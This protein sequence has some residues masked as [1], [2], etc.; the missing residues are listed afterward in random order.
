MGRNVDLRT[1]LYLPFFRTGALFSAGLHLSPALD[2]RAILGQANI[3]S[4]I[5]VDSAGLGQIISLEESADG[6]TAWTTVPDSD[7]ENLSFPGAAPFPGAPIANVAFVTRVAMN[8]RKGFLRM[9][10][11]QPGAGISAA[12]F[13]YMGWP[14]QA[15]APV[16]E[17][18]FL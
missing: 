2:V 8:P 6:V 15:P 14:Q 7:L 18:N 4:A 1:L 11:F 5:G 12:N 13:Y 16:S 9:S 3:Y 10:Y 17:A